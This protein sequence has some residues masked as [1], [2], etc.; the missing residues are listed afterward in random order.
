V[1]TNRGIAYSPAAG[2]CRIMALPADGFSAA[3]SRPE[4]KGRRHE[5]FRG[6]EGTR[7][8]AGRAAWVAYKPKR[9]RDSI[10][11]LRSVLA[12]T[13]RIV[14]GA[15]WGI[16]LVATAGYVFTRRRS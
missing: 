14:C 11:S 13:G 12:L 5:A 7:S 15:T 9:R 2:R 16:S 4:G 8:R 3:S 6:D 1:P 10:G